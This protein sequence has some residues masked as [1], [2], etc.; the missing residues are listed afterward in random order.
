MV[1]VEMGDLW[2]TAESLDG[3]DDDDDTKGGDDDA[4]HDHT[5]GFVSDVFE[6]LDDEAS[7]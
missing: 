7:A 5:D 6:E 1:D 4:P 3:W 2:D